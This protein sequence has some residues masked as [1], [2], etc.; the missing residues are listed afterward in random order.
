MSALRLAWCMLVAT[1]Q[2]VNPNNAHL[3]SRSLGS[4]TLVYPMV[5]ASRGLAQFVGKRWS[6]YSVRELPRAAF[7][8]IFTQHPD[9]FDITHSGKCPC[10]LPLRVNV[11]PSRR[12]INVFQNG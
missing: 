3:L 9:D 10:A 8:Q 11:A 2:L 5:Y 12:E 7:T 4:A 1:Q 6:L